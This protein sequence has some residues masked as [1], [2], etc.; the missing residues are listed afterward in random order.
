MRIVHVLTRLLRGG[1]EE[2]TAEVCRWQAAAG[3]EVWLI[4][5]G[6]AHPAWDAPLAGIR[7]LGLSNLVHPVDPLRDLRALRSLRKLFADLRPDVIHTH[8]SKAGVLGRVAATGQGAWL[9]HGLHILPVEGT[10]LRAAERRA[11]AVTDRFLGVSHAVCDAHVALGLA[12][13]ERTVCVRSGLDLAR[14]RSAPWPADWRA[15]LSCD[16]A[17]PP[18]ILVPAALEPRKNHAAFLDGLAAAGAAARDV[19]VLLAGE[20]PE[21]ARIA[22]RIARLGLGA[23]VRMLGHRSDI[24]GLMAL[25]DMICLPSTREG[26]PRVAVQ[27]MAA[28]RP[29]IATRLPGLGEVVRPGVAGLMAE[30][31]EAVARAALQLL[32]DPDRLTAMRAAA[33]R[34]D[35]SDWALSALG[36]ATTAA[37]GLRQRAA[38]QVA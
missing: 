32:E 29:F 38:R 33:A 36:P 5:G 6:A 15:L 10:L 9:V 31:P 30:G 11:A 20:G 37:Y 12:Q 2:N 25:A 8:Q 16:G 18:V 24:A 7:R 35:V 3:H 17:Q 28:G 14:F 21:A 13:P 34:S 19:R 4:H 23:Q 1:S 22:A 27:A 26:L